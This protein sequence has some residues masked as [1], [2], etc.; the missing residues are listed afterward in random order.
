MFLC[1]FFESGNRS[2]CIY[3]SSVGRITGFYLKLWCGHT[4]LNIERSIRSI[5]KTKMITFFFLPSVILVSYYRADELV[6][7]SYLWER[8]IPDFMPTVNKAYLVFLEDAILTHIFHMQYLWELCLS[9]ELHNFL[10]TRTAEVNLV[11]F[12]HL[13]VSPVI[14]FTLVGF[15]G[16]FWIFYLITMLLQCTS[17]YTE[18]VSA[19]FFVIVVQCFF[20]SKW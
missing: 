19:S 4:V 8:H 20:T 17:W 1:K 5:E 14:F 13:A 7:H 6:L 11:C 9:F 18:V 2:T 12:R 15:G 16:F 10:C 3:M